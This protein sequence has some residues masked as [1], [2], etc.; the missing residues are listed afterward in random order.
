M[1]RAKTAARQAGSAAVSSAAFGAAVSAEREGV[2]LLQAGKLSEAAAKF[3]EASG[4]FRSA[5]LVPET[6]AMAPSPRADTPSSP[7]AAA[8]APPQPAPASPP[9]TAPVETPVQ[10]PP[11]APPVPP[12]LTPV[13]RP[14]PAATPAPQRDAAPLA[15]AED[16]LRD[17]LRR[18]EQALEARNIEALK[19]LW[20]TLQG[21]QEDA[22]RREFMH[23][24]RIAVGIENTDIKVSGQAATVT[25]VRRYQLSTVDGQNLLTNS[26][27]TLSARHAGNEWVIERVRFEALR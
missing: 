4:L 16:G 6:G 17:L 10:T 26:R 24:R 19:R 13:T 20:P 3:Y 23:A 1:A 18:Y 9:A 22:I 15:A 12:P 21:A 2:R 11:A 27:T 8:T 5:E 14:A 7:P 25:F